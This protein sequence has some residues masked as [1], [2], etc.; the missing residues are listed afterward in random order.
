MKNTYLL[1]LCSVIICS[2]GN[3]DKELLSQVPMSLAVNPAVKPLIVSNSLLYAW[4]DNNGAI[5]G[6]TLNAAFKTTDQFVHFNMA[7]GAT[8]GAITPYSF[9]KDTL[10]FATGTALSPVVHY[11]ENDGFNWTSFTPSFSPA[12]SNASGTETL[13]TMTSNDKQ[14]VLAL[15]Y[16]YYGGYYTRTLYKINTNT[17]Q[18]TALYT[19]HDAYTPVAMKFTNSQTGWMLLQSGGTYLSK[20]TD[21]GITWS[22]PALIDSRYLA[23][24]E[25]AAGGV[26]A[27]YNNAGINCF[28]TDGGATWKKTAANN[29][30]STVTIADGG[31]IYA[32]TATGIIKSTNGGSDWNTVFNYNGGGI[33]NNLQHLYFRNEQQ[34]LAYASQQ[35]FLTNDGGSSWKT[36]LYPFPYVVQ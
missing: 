12:L 28:S 36:L 31:I 26:L 6:L 10:V 21:G 9:N 32:L 27:V 13:V 34:G 4:I 17:Q 18:G 16:Q 15:Y 1:L 29:Y 24:F 19:Q 5:S 11:S 3:K 8:S 7:T 22:A 2:C 25:A 23:N 33:V 14:S 30:I 35:L 20:T